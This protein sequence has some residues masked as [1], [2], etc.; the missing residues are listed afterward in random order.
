VKNEYPDLYQEGMSFLYESQSIA[1]SLDE[2]ETWIKYQSN[3]VLKNPGV[4]D[5]RDPKVFWHE[6]SKNWVASIAAQDQ[7]SFYASSDLKNWEK[8]S[9]FGKTVGSHDGVWE[10]P[11]LFPIQ[12]EGKTFWVLIV[13]INPGGPNGGSATQYFVGDFNGKEFKCDF[14]R[15]KWMDYGPDE[16]AGVTWS[17][18]GNRKLFIGWMSN[19]EYANIVPTEKFRNAFTIPRELGLKKI[20]EI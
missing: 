11:D 19:W 9:D 8:L 20:N 6:P 10:C 14:K 4:R 17:N 18:T 3:P 2:G 16:Y 15:V 13:N 7:I 5:F 12:Y 1:Y